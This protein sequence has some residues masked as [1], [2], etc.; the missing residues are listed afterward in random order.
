MAL[1]LKHNHEVNHSLVIISVLDSLRDSDVLPGTCIH[2]AY[3]CGNT[4][5]GHRIKRHRKTITTQNKPRRF[6]TGADAPRRQNTQRAPTCTIADTSATTPR[7]AQTKTT[8]TTGD[9]SASPRPKHAQNSICYIKFTS[10]ARHQQ[11]SLLELA[12]P[13]APMI[14]Q[15]RQLSMF[16]KLARRCWSTSR[17]TTAR[18]RFQLLSYSSTVTSCYRPLVSNSPTR[19]RLGRRRRQMEK[20]R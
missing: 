9:P 14:V 1:S 15:R 12:M 7:R 10:K 5:A 4:N 11:R 16:R 17:R 3:G 6:T 8:P 18:G 2:P 19:R 20:K 13:R